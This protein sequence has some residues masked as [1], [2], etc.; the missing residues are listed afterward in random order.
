MDGYYPWGP[1]G[2]QSSPNEVTPNPTAPY[3]PPPPEPAYEPPAPS[4]SPAYDPQPVGPDSSRPAA[5][6]TTGYAGPP[7]PRKKN[8]AV[9][10]IL[11]LI[12]GPLGLFYATKK[13]ALTMLFLLVAVPVSLGMF[14]ML[15]GGSFS[16]PFT[17]LDHSS[18]M[19][20]M[21]SY[22]AFFSMLWALFAVNSHNASCKSQA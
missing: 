12:F 4:P 20:R 5:V 22:S 6:Q 11:T 7:R 16:H 21:W 13:G 15:P 9:A 2:P 18:V 10:L 17:I 14:G 8:Y 1:H 3:V 19:D